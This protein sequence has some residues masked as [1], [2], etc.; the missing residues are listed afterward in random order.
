VGD[1][2][3]GETDENLR[4]GD[5]CETC[6]MVTVGNWFGKPVWIGCDCDP[7]PEGP[8]DSGLATDQT[9]AEP[10]GEAPKPESAAADPVVSDREAGTDRDKAWR[11]YL[12]GQLDLSAR[13]IDRDKVTVDDAMN[14]FHDW[15]DDFYRDSRAHSP[16]VPGDGQL[17]ERIEEIELTLRGGFPNIADALRAALDGDKEGPA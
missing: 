3:T 2:R 5:T 6:G 16:A 4:V 11:D 9:K 10:L 17:R 13:V 12:I 1:D 15:V 14:A 8:Q 7:H